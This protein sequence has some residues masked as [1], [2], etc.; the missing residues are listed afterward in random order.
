[1]LLELFGLFVLLVKLVI[2][3]LVELFQ[4]RFFPSHEWSVINNNEEVQLVRFIQ[5]P[6]D[7]ASQKWEAIN[8]HFGSAS[9]TLVQTIR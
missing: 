7:K 6:V 3:P 9:Q 4:Q 2:V 1:M 5:L 8:N